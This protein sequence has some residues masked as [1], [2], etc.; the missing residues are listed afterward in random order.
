LWL[1]LLIGLTILSCDLPRDNPY[2][3]KNSEYDALKP[4][5]NLQ[6]SALSPFSIKIKWKD[7]NTLEEGYVIEKSLDGATWD[8][9]YTT[10]ENVE[11]FV[12]TGLYPGYL[13]HYRVYSFNGIYNREMEFGQFVSVTTRDNAILTSPWF[14]SVIALSDSLVLL[15]WEDSIYSNASGN[16]KRG[17]RLERSIDGNSFIVIADSISPYQHSIN[18]TTVSPFKTY[19]YRVQAFNDSNSGPWSPVDSTSTYFPFTTNEYTIGLW[20][21]DNMSPSIITDASGNDHSGQIV[22]LV[23]PLREGGRYDGCYYFYIKPA[24]AEIV[25]PL[26]YLPDSAVAVE[27]YIK[28]LFDLTKLTANTGIFWIENGP[29]EVYYHLGNLRIDITYADSTGDTTISLMYGEDFA[30]T[31]WRLIS[32]VANQQQQTVLVDNH[33]VLQKTEKHDKLKVGETPYIHIGRVDFGGMPKYYKGFIDEV[34]L[35]GT[36]DIRNFQKKM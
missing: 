30:Y 23:I 5:G 16:L 6:G 22:N 19:Y 12:D 27:F 35:L 36:V 25:I 8:S 26:S 15:S 24:N 4:P 1:I 28:P 10:G 20:H 29:L 7:N 18:D 21:M 33:V 31:Q 9:L 11:S 14:K 32:V 34:R 17:F 13:Y 3:P 2:D